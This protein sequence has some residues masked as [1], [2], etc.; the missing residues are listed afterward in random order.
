[1]TISDIIKIR[2]QCN[3]QL[4]NKCKCRDCYPNCYCFGKCEE[5]F[6]R[7]YTI[8]SSED[9]KQIISHL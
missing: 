4:N 9:L 3:K 8:T 7:N 6:C 1:M 5:N 2:E